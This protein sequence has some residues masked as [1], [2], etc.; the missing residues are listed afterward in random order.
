MNSIIILITIFFFIL[1]IVYGITAKTIKSDKDVVKFMEES[2]ASMGGYIELAFV[3]AQFVAYFDWSRIGIILAIQGADFLQWIGLQGIPLILGFIIVSSIINIFVGSASAKWAIMAPV[4]VPM[5]MTMGYSP[6][7]TQLAYRIGDSTTNIISPLMPYFAIIVAFGKKYDKDLGI[8]TLV[9]TMLP[10]S[11]VF[12][13][14]W[15]ILLA[16]WLIA[17]LPIGPG[18]PVDYIM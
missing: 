9:S 10:Y 14:A 13:I 4:F 8:G 1:G 12:M 11:I 17:G 18:A 6:E 16:V 2:M 5:L 7:V 3:A 15:M